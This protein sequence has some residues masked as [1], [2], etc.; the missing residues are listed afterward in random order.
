M[1]IQD[2]HT[3]LFSRPFFDG[4]AA[5]SPRKDEPGLVEAVAAKAGL[6]LPD[7][8]PARHAARWLGEM[9]KHGV[10]RLVSFASLP[11]EAEAVAA[12][13]KSSN[14]RLVPYTIVN[15]TD[16]KAPAFTERALGTL[17][18]RGLL[19]FP[20]MHHFKAGDACMEPILQLA[21]THKAPVLIHCGILRVKLRDA[22]GIPR[23]YDLSFADP[24]HVIPAANR[25]RDVSFVIPHFGG[26]FLQQALAAGASCE[27]VCVDTSS[28]NDWMGMLPWKTSLADVFRAALGVFGAERILFGTDSS[29]FPRGW[30]ADIRDVQLQALE[31]AGAKGAQVEAVLGGNLARLVA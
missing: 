19:T 20:A 15:P 21:R 31:A 22:F 9:D 18:F 16:P 3:H 24:L 26:G 1:Q 4:L 28:S 25:F 17:G 23:P 30:R 29:T 13:A 7:P 14:G 12:A 10:A 6:Q 27:N 2:A 5:L 8:D 11:G